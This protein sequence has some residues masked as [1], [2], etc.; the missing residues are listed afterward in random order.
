[1]KNL[2]K[3]SWQIPFLLFLILGTYYTLT[4]NGK[5]QNPYQEKGVLGNIP[6]EITFQGSHEQHKALNTELATIR[7]GM[8]RAL[9][10]DTTTALPADS[11]R[12]R[13]YRMLVRF[14]EKENL[15]HYQIHI[16]KPIPDKQP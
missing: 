13:I 14:M 11:T 12:A 10:S 4:Q 5:H 7:K 6:Y 2:K 1:M 3:L 9:Q 8:E 16:G 15:E